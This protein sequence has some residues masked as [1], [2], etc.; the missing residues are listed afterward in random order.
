MP[1][2]HRRSA[3][4]VGATAPRGFRYPAAGIH[5]RIEGAGI[6]TH[7]LAMLIAMEAATTVRAS[8]P[9]ASLAR[10][11]LRGPSAAIVHSARALG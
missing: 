4:W 6:R 8:L 1:A 7:M 3:G 9:P 11:R 10:R 2:S 5:A